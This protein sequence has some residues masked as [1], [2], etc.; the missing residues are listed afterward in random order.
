MEYVDIHFPLLESTQKWA[1]EHLRE[2][3][4]KKITCISTEEQTQG[5]GRFEKSWFSPKDQ[6]IYATFCFYLPSSFPDVTCI[7]HLLTLSLAKI[8]S[9]EGLKP[10][11]KWPNDLQLQG[12]KLAG[13]LVELFFKE[14]WQVL[15]GI[16]INVNMDRL[17][18]EPIDQPAT[19]LFKE[20]SFLWDKEKLLQ[21]L[22]KQFQKDVTIFIEQ[23]FTPFY[24]DYEAYMAYKGKKVLCSEA[25]KT[26]EGICEGITPQGYLLLKKEDHSYETIRSATNLRLKN[27]R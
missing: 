13:V 8:L 26:Y 5:K 23:G 27:L 24:S 2:L 12:E 17:C 7:A 9:K 4:P 14:S 11:V 21:S 18:L 22:K 25:G 20:T 19:S 16:G 3:D 6:N 15:A 10:Q 1:K